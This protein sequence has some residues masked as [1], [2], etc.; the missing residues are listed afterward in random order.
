MSSREAV[1]GAVRSS[2]RSGGFG[3]G[4]K[5]A[6]EAELTA[7]KR[8]IIPAR[9]QLSAEERVQLFIEEA[10]AINATTERVATL[11]DIPAALAKYLA[12]ANLPAEVRLAPD[13]LIQSIPW[14]D[15]PTLTTATGPAE[16]TD[17]VAIS[18]AFAGVAETGTLVLHSGPDNPTTLNI[19]PDTH[20]VVLATDRLSGA[21]EEAWSRL[22]ETGDGSMPRTVNWIT[23]PSRTADIEQTL[24]LGAHGPRQLHILLVDQT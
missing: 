14:G 10:E 17:A 20:V 1:L 11:A 24:L 7:H 8:N 13:A 19:L 16:P 12:D 2:L 15:Q 3:K 21:Y 9:A 23:G 4:S 18:A 22:R 5:E 6:I